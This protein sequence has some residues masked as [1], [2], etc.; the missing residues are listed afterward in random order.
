M[1]FKPCIIIPVYNHEN[2]LMTILQQLEKHALPCLLIDD[3]SNITC[4]E[5]IIDLAKH[6]TWVNSIRLEKNRGKGGAVKTGLLWAKQHGYTHAI[7]LDADGQH[8]INDLEKF[9]TAAKINPQAMIIG[10]PIFDNSIPSIRFYAR[11]LTHVWVYINTLSFDIS[12]AMCGYRVY[13]IESSV[14]LINHV[15][16]EERMA[17]DVEI[18]VRLYWQGVDM[19]SIP[20]SVGYPKDGLS[21]FR[22]L[23]DN[24]RISL[25]HAR[26]FCGMLWRLPQLLFNN[27]NPKS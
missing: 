15:V 12:D 8:D 14:Y 4:A 1:H 27:R 17:F 21:H 5:A 3:G 19:I 11:Y 13:P 22:G 2:P 9:I 20:T 7:Q 24:W 26:L 25:T 6:Y 10:K 18:L 23:E 16:L